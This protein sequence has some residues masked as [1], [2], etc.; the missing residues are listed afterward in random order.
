MNLREIVSIIKGSKPSGSKLRVEKSNRRQLNSVEDVVV[1]RRGISLHCVVEGREEAAPFVVR[2]VLHDV[3]RQVLYQL[4]H[5]HCTLEGVNRIART[6]QIAE[7]A[8]LQ[9]LRLH[10]LTQIHY[11]IRF[12]VD[13]F[14]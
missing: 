6:N 11:I 2:L 9:V 4:G 12:T 13:P 1:R 5:F 14:L 3:L 10:E 8:G 7:H